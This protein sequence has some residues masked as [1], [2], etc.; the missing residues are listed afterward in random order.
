MCSARY[1]HEFYW[2]F[3]IQMFLQRF[4]LRNLFST[5]LS[6]LLRPTDWEHQPDLDRLEEDEMS[7]PEHCSSNTSHRPGAAE[8]L[9]FRQRRPVS[10]CQSY[11]RGHI[12]QTEARGLVTFVGLIT[13]EHGTSKMGGWQQ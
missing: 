5:S 2:L 13:L 3:S 11:C 1:L 7:A 6:A 10:L 12:D 4:S 9:P 8:H